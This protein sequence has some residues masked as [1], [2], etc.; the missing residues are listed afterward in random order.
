MQVFRS[1]ENYQAGSKA[2]VTIGTFDGVHLGHTKILQRLIQQA[3]DI[4]G[5]S[6]VIS[7]DPHPRQVLYHSTPIQ[8]LQTTE[9]KIE[10]L[11]ILGI[12]KL[13]LIPFT[14]EFA[15]MESHNF[16]Q[17]VLVQTVQSKKIIIGYDHHFG[18]NRK[19]GLEELRY[20]AP[21][22]GFLVEEIPAQQIDDAAISSTKI[23]QALQRG[24]ISVANRFLGYP[25]HLSGTV[26]H[27]KQ[28]GRTLG[29]PTANLQINSPYKLIPAKGIYLVKVK[30]MSSEIELFGLL[31]IGINPTVSS[32]ND[33]KLEVWILDFSGDLYGQILTVQFLEKIRE[34]KMFES[35]EELQNAIRDD[36]QQARKWLLQNRF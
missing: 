30:L 6:V 14:K 28:L 13:L 23:R 3:D 8:L 36:E 34:E 16:I 27:G 10:R 2:V 9:E 33:L 26:V 20:Y 35:I 5:E 11:S 15:E 22:Y 31:S 32:T 7:F 29:F 1:I 18:K 17:T 4:G 12:Q 25:Y 21:V 24:E 19:G